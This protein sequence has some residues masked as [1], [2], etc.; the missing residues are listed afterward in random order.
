MS[1]VTHVIY[2]KFTFTQYTHLTLCRIILVLY[3][4]TLLL[5]RC[6]VVE[7]FMDV[8][9]KRFFMW[10]LLNSM[11]F[12]LFK[13]LKNFKALS[14]KKALLLEFSMSFYM[15]EPIGTNL[16]ELNDCPDAL[17]RL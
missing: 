5:A 15:K 6:D 2:I 14:E 1:A 17:S 4:L 9:E 7:L 11:I 12:V 16:V 13:V 8:N 3:L 10:I